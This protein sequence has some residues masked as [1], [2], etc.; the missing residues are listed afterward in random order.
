[1]SKPVK[2]LMIDDYR[3]RFGDL[4]AALVVDIRGIGANQN[5]ALRLGLQEQSIRVTVIKNTLARQAFS[6]TQLEPLNEV[7]EGPSALAYGAESVVDVA[8]QLVDWAKKVKELELK[9]AVFDGELFA[10]EAGV[11]RL[12]QLPTASSIDSVDARSSW[13]SSV[14]NSRV[15]LMISSPFSRP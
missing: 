4:T 6:G 5:N 3:R 11:K 13:K 8:R 7:L 10:G 14:S 1:M 9:G 15:S 12:S 2:N